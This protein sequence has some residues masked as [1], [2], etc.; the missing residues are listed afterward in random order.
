MP[1][2]QHHPTASSYQSSGTNFFMADTNNSRSFVQQQNSTGSQPFPTAHGQSS[3]A[4]TLPGGTSTT[5]Q[6]GQ[7]TWIKKG[8]S[9]ATSSASFK[10]PKSGRSSGTNFLTGSQPFPTAHGQSTTALAL[11]GDAGGTSTALQPGQSSSNAS[12][13]FTMVK[14]WWT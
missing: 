10:Q 7:S 1:M 12:D 13:P 5:L 4:L 3:A 11:P 14:G 6:P 8:K 2:S 9:K